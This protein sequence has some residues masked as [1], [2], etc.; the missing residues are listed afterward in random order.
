MYILILV[1]GL[2]T[3]F[4]HPSY[5]NDVDREHKSQGPRIHTVHKLGDLY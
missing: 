5:S 3:K 2:G 4:N 1:R